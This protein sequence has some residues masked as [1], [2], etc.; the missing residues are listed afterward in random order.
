VDGLAGITERIKNDAQREAMELIENARSQAQ[1]KRAQ[2]IRAAEETRTRLLQA[3][4]SEAHHMVERAT[5]T[6]EMEARKA[7]LAVKQEL[8]LSVFQ[9]TL[10]YLKGLED[11]HYQEFL[12]SLV[13]KS[14]LYQNE[15]IIF[16]EKDREKFGPDLIKAV[17]DQMAAEGKRAAMTLS[18]ETRPISGGL[19]LKSGPVETLC[20]LDILIQ[21]AKNN[22]TGDITAILFSA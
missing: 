6:A 18:S 9:E 7:V 4:Q 16:N 19:I 2:A 20:T 10:D 13:L 5:S 14:S 22:L 3:A 17:N 15:E 1:E 21:Q 11:S 12:L 8:V